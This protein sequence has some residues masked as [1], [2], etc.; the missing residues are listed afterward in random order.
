MGGGLPSTNT[1]ETQ[2]AQQHMFLV[3]SG[4][5]LGWLVRTGGV[6][7]HQLPLSRT[8]HTPAPQGPFAGEPLPRPHKCCRPGCGPGV[9]LSRLCS[10]SV[11]VSSAER[12]W[13]C[14][15]LESDSP[16]VPCCG[17][18]GYR[19]EVWG[20]INELKAGGDPQPESVHTR[21]LL[22]FL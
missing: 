8:W 13:A 7:R 14:D 18:G 21:G 3:A 2:A 12:G 20:K 16:L 4:W 19:S 1:Q 5:G 11:S 22:G 9:G 15:W 6:I 17:Q 10:F